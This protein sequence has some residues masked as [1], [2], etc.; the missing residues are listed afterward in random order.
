MTWLSCM[1][2][3]DVRNEQPP[4]WYIL[5]KNGDTL[6]LTEYTVKKESQIQE[7]L[8]DEVLSVTLGQ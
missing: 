7:P 1:H 5:R 2:G 8:T 3:S 4:S 6:T